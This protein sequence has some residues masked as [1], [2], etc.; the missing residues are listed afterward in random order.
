MD[1]QGSQAYLG[2]A[3]GQWGVETL[4]GQST[5][6]AKHQTMKHVVR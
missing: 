5:R 1:L 6:S 4:Q 3:R 2:H